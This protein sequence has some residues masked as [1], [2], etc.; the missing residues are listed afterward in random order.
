MNNDQLTIDNDQLPEGY[1]QTEVGVIPEDWNI[2]E[3]G[4]LGKFKNGINKGSEDFGHGSPFVNLMDVFGI[5]SISEAEHLGLV[6]SNDAEK[7]V[8][9]LR[10]GD[11]LFIRSSV[12]PSGVGLT[13]VVTRDLPNT[14]YS[15][16]LIRFRD[17]ENLETD[18]KKYC[19]SEE[20]FRQRVVANSTVSA[21]TNI[22]QDNLKK[23]NLAYPESA[24]EQ[25]SISQALSDVDALIAGLNKA[26]DKK[27][28]I[29]TATMQ[30]LLTG[31]KRLPGFG[32]EWTVKRLGDYCELITKGT[33]PTSIGR[34]FTVSG[35]NFFKAESISESG[36]PILDKVAFIDQITHKL[37]ERS[38]LKAGDLLISIAGVL[39][40]VGRVSQDVLP[41]N[42]NQALAIV[43]L[44]TLSALQQEFIFYYLRSSMTLKQIKDVNVQGAQANISLQNVQ[45]LEIYVPPTVSEQ[46][47]IATVLS[48]MDAEIAA[49]EI[50]LAKTQA[51]KQGMMQALLT[52]RV[53]LV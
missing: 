20:K 19:F 41:A 49:L 28:A 12:K 27:R 1:Q 31:K 30:Q 33:T 32:S 37:L 25:R 23:L 36:E 13:T 42:T 17:S 11:V 50:R 45:D 51:L 52:G 2:R 40:R 29:K 39:G 35:V 43:R 21:N 4:N 16:F 15:G 9:D 44:G 22:N 38:Q 24:A 5:S 48:D 34:S 10:E 47:A 8:Y 53:R 3:L 14:V 7:K 26:I 18:F 46:C 6:N